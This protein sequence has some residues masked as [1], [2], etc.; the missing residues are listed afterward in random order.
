MGMFGCDPCYS[1]VAWTIRN[2][3]HGLS[4]I[5]SWIGLH[6]KASKVHISNHMVHISNLREWNNRRM[7]RGESA[8]MHVLFFFK[9]DRE[10]LIA[11]NVGISPY[12]S[13]NP[14]GCASIKL[15]VF[16]RRVLRV[17]FEL[18]VGVAGVLRNQYCDGVI[19]YVWHVCNAIPS[20]KQ[21]R[22]TQPW[23]RHINKPPRGFRKPRISLVSFYSLLHRTPSCIVLEAE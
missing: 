9:Q 1:P 19:H 12:M 8:D 17:G 6:M 20:N 7:S 5:K 2:C 13:I 10:E 4:P 22:L 15:V 14:V 3:T 11:V 18:L 21:P 16:R 23:R